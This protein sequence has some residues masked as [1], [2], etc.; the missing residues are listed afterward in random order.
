MNIFRAVKYC[1]I[2]HGRVC[3]MFY[4]YS[5]LML[6]LPFILYSCLSPVSEA[7][8]KKHE[9]A[10]ILHIKIDSNYISSDGIVISS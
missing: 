7:L 2:L 1:C 5:R 3:V 10:L 4:C 8:E 9:A 6:I